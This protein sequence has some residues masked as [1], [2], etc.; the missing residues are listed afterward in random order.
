MLTEKY[1]KQSMI[2]WENV[3]KYDES[4]NFDVCLYNVSLAV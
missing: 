1:E 3:Q 4:N 2:V